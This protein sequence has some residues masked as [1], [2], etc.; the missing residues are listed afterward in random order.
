MVSNPCIELWFLLHFCD[1]T[2]NIKPEKC[3]KELKKH[4]NDYRKGQLSE[5]HKNDLTSNQEKAVERA[6]RLF[7]HK[8]PCTTIYLLI[9]ELERKKRD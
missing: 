5:K 9:D 6:K 2:A 8:N 7:E 3:E 1:Q 4:W